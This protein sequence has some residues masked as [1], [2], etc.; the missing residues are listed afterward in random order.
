M[1]ISGKLQ[2]PAVLVL[3]EDIPLLD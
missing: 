3:G 1:D 2:A